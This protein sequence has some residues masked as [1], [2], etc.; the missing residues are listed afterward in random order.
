MA[1]IIHTDNFAGDYP[2]EKFVTGLPVMNAESA[3]II[4]DAINS[5]TGEHAPRWYAVVEDDYVL[6]PGFEP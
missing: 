4:C 6:Q 5:T 2:D 1:K 3:K